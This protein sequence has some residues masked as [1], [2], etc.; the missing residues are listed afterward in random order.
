MSDVLT[1]QIA[2]PKFAP[3]GLFTESDK[4]EALVWL[5]S[6][7]AKATVERAYL[8]EGDLQRAI[9]DMRL[10]IITIEGLINDEVP[11]PIGV[12]APAVPDPEDKEEKKNLVLDVAALME[13]ERLN[14]E[15]R[16]K[17]IQQDP[18][19]KLKELL[20]LPAH[21]LRRALK[22]EAVKNPSVQFFQAAK[23]AELEGK[24]RK[25][26]VA[27][28]VEIIKLKLAA[29]HVEGRRDARTGLS[30]LDEAYYG[31]IEE[32]Q[33]EDEDEEA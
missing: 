5:P 19:P 29:V 9:A 12:Q 16:A 22:E 17:V 2:S 8:S 32:F 1:F 4:P 7:L 15:A 24:D 26:I 27:L 31:E 33:E 21:K 13:K 11:E 14:G 18:Y 3:W 28:L 20:K 25:T 10:G 30:S 6:H 23:K